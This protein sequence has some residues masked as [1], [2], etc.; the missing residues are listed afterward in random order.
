[1]KN[2]L[3]ILIAASVFAAGTFTSCKKFL[4]EELVTVLTQDEY[5]KTDQGIEDLVKSAYTPLKWKYEGEQAY[6]LYNFGVDEFR[7]GDQFN[8]VQYG[9]Y[10]ANL[11]SSEGLV[12]S[13]WTNMYSGIQRCNLGINYINAYNNPT[14][15]L[16]GTDAKKNA[17]IG[18]LQALRAF[19][20]FELVQQLGGV[21]LMT[22]APATVQTDFPRASVAAVYNQIISDFRSAGPKLPWTNSSERG[23]A[24]KAMAYHFLA[25]AYLTRGSAVADA[26]GQQST[27]MDSC[28]VYADSVIRFSGHALESDY[29]NLF[30]AS[31]PSQLIPRAGTDGVAPITDK[32]K[33]TANNN[34]NEIIF[35]AQFSDNIAL[36]GNNNTA[37]LYFVGQYDAG[38]PG[39]VRDFFNDRPF[40][41]LRPTDYTIDCFD[42]VNDSRFWKSFATVYYRNNT[43][44]AGLATY[45]AADAPTPDVVGRPRIGVGDSASLFILNTP[46]NPLLTSTISAMRYYSVYA[47]YKRTSPTSAIVSDFTSNKYLSLYK[48]IDGVRLTTTNNEARGI[49]NGTL[50]RLAETYLILAEAY[51]RKGNYAMALTN[52]NIVRTRA[53]FKAG[54]ARS[55][56]IWQYLGGAN[57]LNATASTNLATDVLFTT[58]AASEQY[59]STVTSVTDRFIHFMLNERTRELCGELYR[60]QDLVRTETL[61]DRTKLFNADVDAGFQRF[62]K[63]R[64]IP[65]LQIIGQTTNGH[66]MTGAEQAAYQNPGY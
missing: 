49:R 50:A 66:P 47:R 54:E 64:P 45:T 20:Y 31:Y 38:M 5:Y 13:L 51:G 14:S 43:A 28:I 35:A 58:N 65:L 22:Q 21:P 7:N 59:P 9:T 36:A 24:T 32:S 52:V 62:H 55:P 56:Q 19:Y 42:K 46:A 37:H 26:R 6:A 17:R 10:N 30:N 34:S 11:N 12:N 29:G 25:K 41:R 27:D 15:S 3:K 61:F 23:R 18:E 39:M 33:I 1:M 16:L 2:H 48:H 4:K 44:N 63:L 53:A 60:W 8:F 40:R 57:N